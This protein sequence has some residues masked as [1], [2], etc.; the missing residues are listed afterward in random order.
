MGKKKGLIQLGAF[1]GELM[2]IAL[3]QSPAERHDLKKIT[4]ETKHTEDIKGSKILL[5]NHM[6]TIIINDSSAGLS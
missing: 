5:F 3:S 2:H 1:E 4:I 6:P